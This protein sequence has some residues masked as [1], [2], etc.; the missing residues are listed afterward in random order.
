M[1][2]VVI[3]VRKD[4]LST[5]GDTADLL[6][7][8]GTANDYVSFLADPTVR[9][10]HPFVEA[11]IARKDVSQGEYFVPSKIPV[12]LVSGIFDLTM[13]ETSKYGFHGPPQDE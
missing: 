7:V 8:R 10:D 3:Y 11:K 2:M 12:G 4:W 13:K 9:V 1:H 6:L 5:I